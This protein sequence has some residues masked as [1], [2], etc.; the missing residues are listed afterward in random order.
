MYSGNLVAVCRVASSTLYAPHVR[1]LSTVTCHRT[2]KPKSALL[3]VP[4][5][6]YIYAT[7]LAQINAHVHALSLS[8]SFGHENIFSR[9][10]HCEVCNPWWWLTNGTGLGVPMAVGVVHLGLLSTTEQPR[11]PLSLRSRIEVVRWDLEIRLY[12]QSPLFISMRRISITPY[13]H[14]ESRPSLYV[15]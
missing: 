12:I 15:K 13:K 3:F 4:A 7:Y 8:L 14:A 6:I 5:Y 9:I 11:G 2:R 10:P 1:T